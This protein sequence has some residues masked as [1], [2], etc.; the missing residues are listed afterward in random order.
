MKYVYLVIAAMMLLC[1]APMPYGYYM[2]VRF[3]AMVAF[4]I[5]A[6]RYFGS[7]KMIPAV[8]QGGAGPRAME[9][10]RC[11]CGHP[12]GCPVCAGYKGGETEGG[13]FAAV[14]T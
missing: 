10:G 7:G 8:L 14:E 12:D 3:V 11:D 6:I 5:L 4:A 9:C 2:L 13:E 1:L